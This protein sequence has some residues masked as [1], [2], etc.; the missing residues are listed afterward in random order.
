VLEVG[1]RAYAAF[2]TENGLGKASAFPSLQTMYD[3]VLEMGAS[4]FQ[5]PEGWGGEMTSGG[6]ESIFLAVQSCRDWTRQQ[7]SSADEILLAQS[8]HPAFDKAAGYLGLRVK[9]LPVRED[10]RA[11]V[12]QFAAAASK[13]TMMIVGSAPNYPYGLVDPVIELSDLALERGLWLH[14]D[15]CVGG[16]FLPWARAN[17]H[18]IP[19]FDFS[20][21][22]VRSISADLHKYGFAPKAASTL[23]QR[24]AEQ[25]AAQAFDFDDW[26]CGRMTTHTAAGTRPGGAIAGAWAVLQYLGAEGYRERARQIATAHAGFGEAGRAVGLE[27]MPSDLPILVLETG[28]GLGRVWRGLRDEG[29]FTGVVT[30]P[31]GLHLMVQPKHAE[32]VEDFAAALERAAEGTRE[33]AAPRYA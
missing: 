8:A 24:S 31:A 28:K 29:W 33:G 7:G 27:P 32:L 17:S 21:P 15:A 25:H 11:D 19:A 5:A 4:L 6:T 9:R 12:D 1:K 23:F 13:E 2:H 22:G 16:Y 20:V 30:A 3:E 14:V 18:E 26:P 10:Y